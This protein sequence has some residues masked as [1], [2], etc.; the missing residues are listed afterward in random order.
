MA[1]LPLHLNA[2]RSGLPEDAP[3]IRR[4]EARRLVKGFLAKPEGDGMVVIETAVPD[5]LVTNDMIDRFLELGPPLGAIIPEF[6]AI[7]NEIEQAYVLRLDFSAV[8]AACVTIERM[9]NLARK[10]L[11]PY[12]WKIKDLWSKGAITDWGKNIDALQRWG[13]LDDSFAAELKTIGS[14]IRNTYLHSAP[15]GDMRKDAL[16]AASS[17]HRLIELFLGVPGT[18]FT[19]QN[20]GLVCKNE[21]DPRYIVFYKP[22]IVP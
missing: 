2:L 21:K 13:Y 10:D 20:G 4:R 14:E 15:I 7:I 17:A 12:H 9:L 16:R 8:S 1:R 18:L 22:K 3:E 11:H 6:Q 19:F 5:H